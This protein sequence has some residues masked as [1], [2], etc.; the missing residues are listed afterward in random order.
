MLKDKKNCNWFQRWMMAITFAEMGEVKT[1]RKFLK[2][3]KKKQSKNV[4]KN[5]NNEQPRLWA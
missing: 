2:I 4:I 3:D 5:F 1:A